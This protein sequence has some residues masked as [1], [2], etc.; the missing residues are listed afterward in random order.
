MKDGIVFIEYIYKDATVFLE[1]KK[2]IS[3]RFIEHYNVKKEL[4]I[5]NN[6]IGARAYL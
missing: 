2:E 1:R 3:D 4:A 6:F 5:N